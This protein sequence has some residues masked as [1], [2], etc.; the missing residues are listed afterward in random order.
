MTYRTAGPV[1][2][3]GIADVVAGHTARFPWYAQLVR[4]SGDPAA[5]LA[6]LPLMDQAVLEQHYYSAPPQPGASTYLTSGTSGGARK[7]IQ[8]SEADDDAYVDQ[9]RALFTDFLGPLTPGAVAV[10]DLGTGHAASSARTVFQGLGLDAR[11]IDF[12]APVAEH[13]GLLNAWQPEALFTMPMILDRILQADPPLTA[14]PRKVIVVGDLAPPAWRSHVAARFG[15]EPSDVLDIVGS[16][17]IGAIAYFEASYGRYVFHD[18]I[19]AEVVPA[20]LDHAAGPA[21]CRDRGDGVL[22]LTSLTREFFPAVRYV[23][24]DLVTGLARTEVRGRTVTTFERLLGRVTGDLKHGERISGYDL[25]EAM[26]KVFPGCPFEVTEGGTLT[27]R[28]VSDDV[29]EEKRRALVAAIRRAAPDVGTMLDSGL[30]GDIAVVAVPAD[31]LRSG[32]G[33]RCFFLP[34]QS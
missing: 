16:I 28:V 33:K 25:S 1:T 31:G 11:D 24:G 30:V 6:R 26:A 17:E 27:V 19:V 12:T 2:A 8:Y 32:P 10:A 14:R 23:T 7:R 5:G 29:D 9:R 20:D 13:V 34:E 3:S 4:D 22:V 15:I 18:H 21:D